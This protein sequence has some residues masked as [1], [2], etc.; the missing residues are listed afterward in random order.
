MMYWDKPRCDHSVSVPMVIRVG[1]KRLC[2]QHHRW[3][4]TVADWPW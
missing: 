2:F 3:Q 1:G 4:L